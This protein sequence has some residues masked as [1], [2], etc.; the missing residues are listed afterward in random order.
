MDNIDKYYNFSAYTRIPTSM[1][2]EEVAGI[3]GNA[4]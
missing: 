1:I 4:W 3:Y 2:S